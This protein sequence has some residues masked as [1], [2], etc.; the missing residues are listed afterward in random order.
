MVNSQFWFKNQIEDEEY[1]S[2][3]EAEKLEGEPELFIFI[4][5]DMFERYADV[6]EVSYFMILDFVLSGEVDRKWKVITFTGLS[7]G[8]ILEP[9]AFAYIDLAHMTIPIISDIL[10]FIFNQFKKAPQVLIT[11]ADLVYDELVYTMKTR[12][13]FHGLHFYD[14][15]IEIDKIGSS[16]VKY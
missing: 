5:N 2:K 15:I 1:I 13:I 8:Y 16:L 10:G 7:L 6:G 12:N 4:F 11:P 14:P 3:G 9:F